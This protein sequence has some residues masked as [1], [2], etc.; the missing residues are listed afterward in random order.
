MMVVK[1]MAYQRFLLL[2]LH[3]TV[4][5]SCR[6]SLAD[7]RRSTQARLQHLV[8]IASLCSNHC[9]SFNRNQVAF[10]ILYYGACSPP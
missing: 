6:V 4:T 7:V 2:P 9:A 8:N 10:T 1:V 5:A 3:C